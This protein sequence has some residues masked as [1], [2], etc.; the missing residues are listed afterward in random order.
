MQLIIIYLVWK[1]ALHVWKISLTANL[2]ISLPFLFSLVLLNLFVW[3]PLVGQLSALIESYLIFSYVVFIS[4]LYIRRGGNIE[5][6]EED[7]RSAN[8]L[9]PVLSY[10]RE[11]IGV[12]VAQIFLTVV[13]LL[14]SLVIL[15]A[16]GA[17]S[18]I[19]PL[20]EGGDV[21][22]KG[23]LLSLLI[24]VFLY[25]SIVSSFPIFFGRAM[26][27]GKGFSGTLSTFISSLWAE[28]SWRTMLSWDYIKSSIVVSLITFGFLLLHLVLLIP[29]L[30][31]FGP[32]LTFLTVHF[33]YTFGTVACLRLLRS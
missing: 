21:S 6:F 23:L 1:E 24:A 8:L 31:L 11:V 12:L 15:S 13:A 28:I 29:P 19:K 9:S 7:L 32:I 5:G 18:V 4:K 16:G 22:W 25:F 3:I 10:P 26:L 30:F 2:Y 27:R 17:L 14:V 33:L 20:L